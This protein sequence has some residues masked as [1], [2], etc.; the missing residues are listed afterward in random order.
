MI[1][2]IT[3]HIE[4]SATEDEQNLFY[5]ENYNYWQCWGYSYGYYGYDQSCGMS[6]AI[7]EL[8]FIN[9]GKDRGSSSST[10]YGSGAGYGSGSGNGMGGEK[11]P[12]GTRTHVYFLL[13]FWREASVR[14]THVYLLHGR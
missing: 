13:C 3:A 8:Q 12:S 7:E 6:R 4:S 1:E 10:M 5:E 11:P 9:T 2:Q 14:Y